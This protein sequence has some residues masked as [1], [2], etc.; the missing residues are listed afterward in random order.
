MKKNSTAI[1]ILLV[2][3]VLT[4][5]LFPLVGAGL[6][7]AIARLEGI[8]Y[9]EYAPNLAPPT[10]DLY[11]GWV[12]ETS[13]SP[14]HNSGWINDRAT[15][16]KLTCL[17]DKTTPNLI[18]REIWEQGA[19]HWY[20]VEF[21]TT[22]R[23]LRTF[24]L[25]Q[26]NCEGKLYLIQD[27]IYYYEFRQRPA[28][29]LRQLLAELVPMPEDKSEEA[30]AQWRPEPKFGMQLPEAD[31]VVQVMINSWKSKTNQWDIIQLTDD[32]V[33]Q[34]FVKLLHRH[35]DLPI[36][37]RLNPAKKRMDIYLYTK[38]GDCLTIHAAHTY[39]PEGTYMGTETGFCYRLKPRATRQLEAL[40]AQQPE[41]KLMP[42]PNPKPEPASEVEPDP[43]FAALD[44]S[45][46]ERIL[47]PWKGEGSDVGCTVILNAAQ[48]EQAVQTLLAAFTKMEPLS[49][50][51][52]PT[53]QME[54]QFSYGRSLT[55]W[56]QPAEDGC[57][58][59]LAWQPPGAVSTGA[60]SY[61]LPGED[62]FAELFETW[63]P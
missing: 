51:E 16:R 35:H 50:L 59:F 10:W 22:E 27:H 18:T 58:L 14:K 23:E 55:V 15:L 21:H 32:A 62:P 39:V 54:L 45:Q 46:V 19:E 36:G 2:S 61:F 48:T 13:H 25:M 12:T 17:L 44:Y 1:W 26:S 30:A 52:W 4:I 42:V 56:Y 20:T 9:Q 37:L 53:Q 63:K 57:C 7:T 29:K 41:Q 28:A 31:Q 60:Y 43:D 38:D 47:V 8:T 34:E 24:Y 49:M 5:G 11:G 3:F 33:V 40:L 6:R